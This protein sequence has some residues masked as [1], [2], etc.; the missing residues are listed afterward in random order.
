LAA[1]PA[2]P[3]D[4]YVNTGGVTGLET[5]SKKGDGVLSVGGGDT[6]VVLEMTDS[7]RTH[8]TTYLSEAEQNRGALASLGLVRTAEQLSGN[9]IHT[10][11]PRRLVMAFDP[12]V[13]DPQLLRTLVQL[14]RL[15]AEAAAAR[16]ESGEL[17]TADQRIVEALAALERLDRIKKAAGQIRSNANPVDTEAG[18]VQADLNRLLTQARTAPRAPLATR[19]MMQPDLYAELCA[20]A[21]P[22]EPPVV[23]TEH[24]VVSEHALA[25][26]RER[27]ESLP[28]ARARRALQ[29]LLGQAEWTVRPR[30]WMPI[31]L[32][33]GVRYGYPLTRP[34]VCLL[35]REEFVVTV[36][37]KR[38][39]V[40]HDRGGRGRH[41]GTR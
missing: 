7:P 26:Y 16:V 2:G 38:F 28:R 4:E 23:D 36:M 13:D 1:I 6:R 27:V 18:P 35:V 17:T 5:R 8:W 37:S 22:D 15:A 40:R 24:L 25:R 32:H 20:M 3:G 29:R 11:C 10:L 9:S 14:Q 33:D 34:D 39:L 19:I 31:V 30:R 12:E 41:D 21:L